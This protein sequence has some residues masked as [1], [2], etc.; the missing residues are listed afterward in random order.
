M[1]KATVNDAGRVLR[2]IFSQDGFEKVQEYT[3]IILMQF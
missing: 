3:F 1:F 2:L